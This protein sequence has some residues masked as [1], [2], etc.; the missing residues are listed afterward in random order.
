MKGKT[1]GRNVKKI[2]NDGQPRRVQQPIGKETR[3]KT[4]SGRIDSYHGESGG[5]NV[6]LGWE[7]SS[8]KG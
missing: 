8:A 3:E 7:W 5:I 4:R 6:P 1:E 2:R